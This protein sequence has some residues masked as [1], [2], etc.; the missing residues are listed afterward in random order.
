MPEKVTSGG[1]APSRAV[2]A[3]PPPRAAE[4]GM[5]GAF[6]SR[7]IFSGHGDPATIGCLAFHQANARFPNAAPTTI[8]SKIVKV[9]QIATNHPASF[10]H[11][12]A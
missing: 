7:L 4:G 5:G 6:P 3:N 9:Y 12:S 10:R 2:T 8:T 1:L 11:V